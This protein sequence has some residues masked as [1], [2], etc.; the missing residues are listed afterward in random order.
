MP[1]PG[2]NP[3]RPGS[4]EHREIPGSAY[5]RA[6]R[7]L[8]NDT[9]CAGWCDGRV[10]PAGSAGR[11][12]S[13]DGG[14][15]L[16]EPRGA[17]DSDRHHPCGG[18]RSPPGAFTPPGAQAALTLPAFCRV[19]AT[20]RPTTDSEIKFEVWI[21]P[22]EAWNG[23]FQG[24]GNGGYQG[25][26]SYAAMATALRRGYATAST[27]TGH[28]GDDMKFGQ[29]HPE[30]VIDYGC[31]AVH[32]MTETAK[33]IVRNAQGRFADKSYFVGCSAGGHQAMSEAQRYPDDY[34]GIVAGDPAHNRIRQTFGFLW[35]WIATTHAPDGKPLITQPKLALVTKA[36]VE[37]CDG[38]DG[39]KDGLIADPRACTFDPAK[40]P[41]KAGS[42]EA[43]C[44]TPPQVDAIEEGVRGREEPAHRRA[45]LH[46]LAARQRG[47][48]RGARPELAPVPASIPRSRCASGFFRYFL[49]H[50]PSWDLRTLDYDRDLAYA[51]QRLAH[52]AAV[53]RDLSPFKK[54]GGKLLMY[55]GWVD[56]VVPPQDTAPYYEAVAKTMGGMTTD[57][58]L[59]PPLHGAG[60][61]PLRGGPGPNQFDAL[62]G[63]RA[64]GGERRRAGDAGRLAQQQRQ[65][66]PD[67]AA[68]RLPAGGAL[69]GHRQHRRCGELRLRRA[70]AGRASVPHPQLT[71][72][73]R[74]ESAS[75][76]PPPAR[77]DGQRI[78]SRVAI[79]RAPGGRSYA[80]W[81]MPRLRATLT[82]A[83]RSC[84]SSFCRMLL[85]W[86][87][88]VSSEIPQRLAISRFRRPR[89]ISSSTSTSRG[90]STGPA[91]R[92]ASWAFTSGL[93]AGWTALVHLA[94]RMHEIGERRVLEQVGGG[95]GLERPEDV[96]VALEHRQHDDARR[97]ID[98]ANR[99]DGVHARHPAQLQVHHR[100]V[101]AEQAEHLDRLLA[102]TREPDHL[103]V[104]LSPE[105]HREPLADD[106]VVVDAE[107]ANGNGA[108]RRRRLQV[109][110]GP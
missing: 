89:W 40:L 38:I 109:H 96:L 14:D 87:C 65:G 93:I 106:A 105:Q 11:G 10:N 69:Q 9:Q 62:D 95:A 63:A 31:R 79:A 55:T 36:V 61:G 8:P 34:D 20:A 76:Q 64:M 2:G 78:R 47:L 73:S 92:R 104:A 66:R 100:D 25:S 53:T 43:S 60:H 37:A 41:C 48:R 19:E 22:V 68:L 15:V 56:P 13:G 50:D 7:R 52:M 28:T 54:R 90:V 74:S 51:E 82:A 1:W 97:G 39:L 85:T 81:M 102:G 94:D 59:L 23:K 58:G 49:F 29:G 107:D 88:T 75:S 35:S 44:L 42:D 71:V 27:D 110:T 108:L 70:G 98:P 84:A 18:D 83:V 77:P 99:G 32:L 101:R 26:I 5:N 3:N 91:A 30:K 67:A 46:R 6:V 103:H 12:T 33:L 21:P 45:D 86:V 4:P 17:D 80:M 72:T 16:R 57:A 24:V